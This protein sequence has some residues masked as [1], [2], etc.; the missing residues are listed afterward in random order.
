[1]LRREALKTEE[2]RS[3]EFLTQVLF[4]DVLILVQIQI[5]VIDGPQGKVKYHAI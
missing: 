5:I 2:K 4:L 3:L 1:M